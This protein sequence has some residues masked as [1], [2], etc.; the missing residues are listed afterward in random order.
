MRAFLRKRSRNPAVWGRGPKP[1][2]VR[3]LWAVAAFTGLGAQ[4]PGGMPAGGL[5]FSCEKWRK[6]HQGGGVSS[7]LDP[8]SQVWDILRG[9]PLFLYPGL[10]PCVRPEKGPAP[11]LGGLGGVGWWT[12]GQGR[13]K[14]SQES[15]LERQFPN[16]GPY[17]GSIKP[18]D[19]F[20]ASLSQKM[21][22]ASS[23]RF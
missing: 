7:S 15:F 3:T 11:W 10:R 4:R 2:V 9:I 22:R 17:M 12:E 8:P 5:H 14:S 6:E 16:Q 19:R 13:E 21:E 20:A 18:H 23:E 1:P